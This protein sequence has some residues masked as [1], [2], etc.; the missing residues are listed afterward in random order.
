MAALREYIWDNSL[1]I[2]IDGCRSGSF[3]AAVSCLPSVRWPRSRVE[4]NAATV[5]DDD[6][7]LNCIC[8]PAATL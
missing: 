3:F 7:V 4:P 6:S 8:R 2:Y 1:Y 5:Y